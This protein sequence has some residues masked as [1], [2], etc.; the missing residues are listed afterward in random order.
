MWFNSNLTW[1][2]AHLGG[3]RVQVRFKSFIHERPEHND[4]C[5]L[6]C[7]AP[8][9][10]IRVGHVHTCFTIGFDLMSDPLVIGISNREVDSLLSRYA[11]DGCIRHPVTAERSRGGP[12]PRTTCFPPSSAPAV[13]SYLS[14]QGNLHLTEPKVGSAVLHCASLV[15]GYRWWAIARTPFSYIPRSRVCLSDKRTDAAVFL[16]YVRLSR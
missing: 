6:I 4:L 11:L 8:P 7:Q 9:I 3:K 1:S 5:K 10:H 16:V 12:G 2:S 15:L 13:G 14:L